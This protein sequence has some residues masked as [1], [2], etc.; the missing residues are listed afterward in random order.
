MAGLEVHDVTNDLH[1]SEPPEN[2]RTEYENKFSEQGVPIN[3]CVVKFGN[4]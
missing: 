3:F 4:G 1:A 2:I